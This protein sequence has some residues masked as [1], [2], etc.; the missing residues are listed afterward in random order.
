MNEHNKI[1]FFFYQI[2]HKLLMNNSIYL[3][4]IF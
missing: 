3:V 4:M 2:K 1:F